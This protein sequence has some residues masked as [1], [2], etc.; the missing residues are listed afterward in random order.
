M[1]KEKNKFR[2]VPRFNTIKDVIYNS[3]NFYKFNVAFVTKIKNEDGSVKY[4]EHTYQDFLN[5]VNSFGTG[6]YKMNL[7]GKKIAILRKK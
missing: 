6:L 7:K 4:L 2:E 5:D 1:Q 3:V